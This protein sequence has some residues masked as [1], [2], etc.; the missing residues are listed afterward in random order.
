[1]AALLLFF[2]LCLQEKKRRWRNVLKS[3]RKKKKRKS[4]E[5]SKGKQTTRPKDRRPRGFCFARDGD[6]PP[7]RS[8]LDQSTGGAPAVGGFSFAPSKRSLA[9]LF[10]S[11]TRRRLD[12]CQSARRKEWRCGQSTLHPSVL[13]VFFFSG[14]CCSPSTA[15]ISAQ[16]T[17]HG[18]RKKKRSRHQ[19][20]ENTCVKRTRLRGT[21]SAYPHFFR[22]FFFP[23]STS[24][25][26]PSFFFLFLPSY[27]FPLFFF[28][29]FLFPRL[30]GFVLFDAA[31]V[32]SVWTTESFK[33][34]SAH[35]FFFPQSDR[36][37]FW[38]CARRQERATINSILGVFFFPLP[39]SLSKRDTKCLQNI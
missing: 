12:P 6:Q 38:R 19:N 27:H 30:C 18:A 21:A 16:K 26:T 15:R 2:F 39:L 31:L 5:V 4:K 8:F 3:L 33:V 28:L 13:S 10:A 11:V 36:V 17:G 1:M 23:V 35:A 20:M 7:P 32:E 29:S 25:K 34:Q 9:C 14:S 37:G 24:A 22:P